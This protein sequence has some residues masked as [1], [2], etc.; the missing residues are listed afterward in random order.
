MKLMK[1]SY[2]VLF[3]S[4]DPPVAGITFFYFNEI[5]LQDCKVIIVRYLSILAEIRMKK[6]TERK[7]K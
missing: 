7:L 3:K 5:S 1:N 6:R 4:Q 2:S